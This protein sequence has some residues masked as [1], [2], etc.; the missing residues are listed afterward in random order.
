M[1]R[2]GNGRGER[3]DVLLRFVFLVVCS[4]FASLPSL[5]SLH[6]FVPSLTIT[7]TTTTTITTGKKSDEKK[8]GKKK[9]EFF[10][11]IVNIRIS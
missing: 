1:G 10:F 7:I 4:R 5:P 8:E 6:P 3:E 11:E 9:G 2:R